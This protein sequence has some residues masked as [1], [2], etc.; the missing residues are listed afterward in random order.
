MNVVP[1]AGVTPSYLCCEMT[2]GAGFTLGAAGTGVGTGGS[3]SSLEDY[4]S[5]EREPVRILPPG[6]DDGHEQ[7][8]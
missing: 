8:R 3:C 6:K 5:P 1:L 7:Y 2:G 4:W